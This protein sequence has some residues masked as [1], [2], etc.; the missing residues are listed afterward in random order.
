M[1]VYDRYILPHL[2]NLAC[3]AKPVR[4]QRRKVVPQAQGRVLEVGIGSGLNLPFYDPAKVEKLWA[5]EPS[6]DIRRM[7]ERRAARSPF[8]IEFIDLPG[9][10]IPLEAGS[11]DTV[12]TTYTL[13]TIPDAVT[14]LREMRRVLRPGGQLLFSEHGRAPDPSVVRWQDRLDPLWSKIAGGCH[15]NREI[16][17]LLRQGGFAIETLETMYIP[18]PRAMSFNYWGA[19]APD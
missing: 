15:L 2:I 11:V 19:A 6:D 1:G 16:P 4:L 12:V 5:L 3:G 9:E 13:C 17:A 8:P 14:A 7:A 10:M 18:G